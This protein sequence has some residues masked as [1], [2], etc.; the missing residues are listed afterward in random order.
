[1]R[2]AEQVALEAA[3]EVH[4]HN[5]RST[6]EFGRTEL[7]VTADTFFSWLRDNAKEESE[8]P[9]GIG[10]VEPEAIPKTVA[11]AGWDLP[12]EF[13]ISV[14]PSGK[15]L[16]P[17]CNMSIVSLNINQYK[18]RLDQE[19]HVLQNRV[20]VAMYPCGHVWASIADG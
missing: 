20:E 11:Y 13:P 6:T 2:P 10:P 8:D 19:G 5:S 15:L 4:K 1:M 9:Y 16:C 7:L 14:G 17:S 18:D 3:V 12:R